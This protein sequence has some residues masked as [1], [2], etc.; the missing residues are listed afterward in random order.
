MAIT[1][2]N[3]RMLDGS[4]DITSQVTGYAEGTWTP[5]FNGASS[6]PTVTYGTQTGGYV[7]IGKLV[8]IQFRLAVSSKS[9]GSG[10][11]MVSGLPY[12]G[13]GLINLSVTQYHGINMNSG[14][15]TVGGYNGA[16]GGTS[17]YL[18]SAGDNLSDSATLEMSNI[19]SSFSINGT[20]VYIT[21]A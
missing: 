19:N 14:H 6:S 18:S 16:V 20:A 11:A 5:L 9:G 21:N 8:M 3:T 7:K 12:G 15:T 1:K 2:N 13:N 10:A 17:I 4:I